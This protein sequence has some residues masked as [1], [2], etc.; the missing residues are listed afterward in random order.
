MQI[1]YQVMYI[2]KEIKIRFNYQ[3]SE[4]KFFNISSI[5][6]SKTKIDP[7]IL[8]WDRLLISALSRPIRVT[9][10]LLF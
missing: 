1:F 8:D 4:L 7:E 9:N 10:V 2:F 6:L 3:T 5:K